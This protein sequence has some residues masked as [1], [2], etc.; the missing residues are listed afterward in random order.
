MST[1]KGKRRSSHWSSRPDVGPTVV[2][3]AI[4]LP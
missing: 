1:D 4:S 3:S 2:S